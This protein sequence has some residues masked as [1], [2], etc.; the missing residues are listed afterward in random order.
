[1]KKKLFIKTHGC[2][3]NEYDSAK[4]FDLLEEKENFELAESE[5][6]AD[7]LILNTCSIRE[8]AQE[9]VFHQVGRWRKIK[10]KNP[11]LKI[12]IG[13]C[14]ASQE[15][16]NI[17]KRA[18]AVD[19]VF[20]PQTL[21]KLPELYKDKIHT[22]E[23]QVDIS[24]P[25]LEKF[26]HIP[27]KGGGEPSAFV[28][29][30]EGCNKYCSF[31]VVPKTRGH[32]ISRTIEDIL[33][34]VSVLA[35][36]GTKEIHFLGQNV[37][38]FKG[39]FKGEKSSLSKL[40]E[41][42]SK[43]ENIERIRFT[44]SHPHEFKDDL[45]ETY[46]KVPELVSHVHLPIQSGSDRILKMMRRRY[47]VEKYLILIDKIRNIRPDM[48][49][50]SDFIIGFPGE[51]KT[52]FKYTMDVINEVKFDESFSF[53]YSPRPNT[54]ASDMDDD[55]SNDEKKERLNILQNRLNQLSYGYS[56]KMVGNAEDCLVYGYSK[57]DPGQLQA[58]TICNRVVNFRAT[59]SNLIGQIIKLKVNEALPNCLRGAIEN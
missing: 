41:L 5:D 46:D 49:F 50:S 58:R 57:R 1:M 6:Q 38:N 53:I 22:N 19:I 55:V 26:N 35:D 45:V 31:C 20:G 14:V 51:T 9:K 42:S 44:T 56:R 29:I 28:S 40:I 12:A 34:E 23:N 39:T 27:M 25:K 2:Q 52:D 16:K 21:H 30:I 11:N 17:I 4:M 54:P 8:K 10:E 7:L 13:G 32:E 33:N 47:N 24:F 59:D 15:G 43:I 48:R 18:P 3:M 36:K 37:N